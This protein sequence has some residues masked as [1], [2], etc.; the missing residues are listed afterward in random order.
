MTGTQIARV[1]DPVEP[2]AG[3]RILVDRLWPRGL[4][5]DDPRIGTWYP[6][7]APST[8]LRRWYGHDPGKFAEF[9]RRY[10]EELDGPGAA[11]LTQLRS[12]AAAGPVQLVTASKDLEHSEAAVL[13]RIL[14]LR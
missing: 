12:W 11:G 4:R 1:Y 3:R 5:K 14:D 2:N 6:D 8:E 7:A 13:A 9:E 10:R